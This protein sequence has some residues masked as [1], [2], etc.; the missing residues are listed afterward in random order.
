VNRS[1]FKEGKTLPNVS[2]FLK[3]GKPFQMERISAPPKVNDLTTI[4]STNSIKI[5]GLTNQ[6]SPSMVKSY[7]VLKLKHFYLI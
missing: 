5:V 2:V 1:C 7:Q 3:E 6:R 4:F